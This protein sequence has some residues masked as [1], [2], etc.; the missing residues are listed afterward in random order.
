MFDPTLGGTCPNPFVNLD[1][2]VSDDDDVLPEPTKAAQKTL[3]RYVG[4]KRSALRR[5]TKTPRGMFVEDIKAELVKAGSWQLR[6]QET[7]NT[8][9]TPKRLP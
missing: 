4:K 6:W 1:E 7:S 3:P 9:C 5:G 2:P 8:T